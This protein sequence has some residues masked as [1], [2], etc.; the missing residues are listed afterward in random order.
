LIL[1]AGG[2]ILR[3]RSNQKLFQLLVMFTPQNEFN[4]AQRILKKPGLVAGVGNE[5]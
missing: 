3:G 2:A 1:G 4:G 5:R